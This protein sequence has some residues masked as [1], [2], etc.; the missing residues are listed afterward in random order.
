MPG[1]G[2]TGDRTFV[3]AF[4]AIDTAIINPLFMATFFG[5]LAFTAAAAA[6]QVGDDR[7]TVLPWVGGALALYVLVLAITIRVHVPLNDEI[8]P[9]ARWRRPPPSAASPGP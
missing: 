3:G 2:K 1:L 5:T 9:S 8:K 6:L 4:Q 7:S